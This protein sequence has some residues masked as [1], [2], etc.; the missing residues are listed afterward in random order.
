MLVA[1]LGDALGIAKRVR[2]L[3]PDLWVAWNTVVQR[4]EIHD[5]RAPRG[6]SLVMRVQEPNGAFRPLDNRVLETLMKNRRERFDEVFKEL[7]EKE[8]KREKAWEKRIGE[9]AE[10]MADD[11]RF[12]GQRVVQGV[13]VDDA[14]GDGG[15]GSGGTPGAV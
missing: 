6:H 15:S 3:D 8:E 2:E 9:I 13:T 12:A 1:V 4:Y 11:L 5:R 10:G 7:E 14:G